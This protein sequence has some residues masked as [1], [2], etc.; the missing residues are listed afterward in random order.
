MASAF[1]LLWTA[2]IFL[3][4]VR[5]AGFDVLPDVVGYVLMV[6]GLKR[7]ASLNGHFAAAAKLAPLTALVSLAD[8]YQPPVAGA[9]LLAVGG[10]T[11]KT[12]V[13]AALTIAGIVLVALNLF[14]VYHIMAGIIEVA[15]K[16]KD[17]DVLEA[18]TPLWGE[19]RALHILLLILI[20]LAAFMPS[21]NWIAPLAQLALAIVVYIGMMG[22]LRLAQWNLFGPAATTSAKK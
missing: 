19:Y 1:D 8:F 10:P 11:F 5:I 9:S 3:F 4:D 2:F 7:L 22:F 15:T 21:F 17:E 20:P 6:I 13:G 12:P 16:K 14:L 18:A